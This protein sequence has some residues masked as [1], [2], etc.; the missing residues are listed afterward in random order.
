MSRCFR[1]RARQH[2]FRNI[3]LTVFHQKRV[4]HYFY[5]RLALLGELIG[6]GLSEDSIPLHHN[7]SNQDE[8]LCQ[9]LSKP[10]DSSTLHA[11]IIDNPEPD[12]LTWLKFGLTFRN[13]TRLPSIKVLSH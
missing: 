3:K 5:R 6:D 9:I 4:N 11:L 7:P 2:V 13:L 12:S 1:R 10:T 8:D